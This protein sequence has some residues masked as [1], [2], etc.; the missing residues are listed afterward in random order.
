[1][2]AVNASYGQTS[3]DTG[4][5]SSEQS[6]IKFTDETT[7]DITKPPYMIGRAD[8]D[9]KRKVLK[10]GINWPG[11]D[12]DASTRIAMIE[13][14]KLYR[15]TQAQLPAE[16]A[17]RNC[18]TG[19][20]IYFGLHKNPNRLK[21]FFQPT[22]LK[23]TARKNDMETFE[24]L[25]SGTNYEYIDR[26]EPAT[27]FSA[28][29]INYQESMTVRSGRNTVFY[30]RGNF[31]TDGEDGDSRKVF[32]TFQEIIKFYDFM[33]NES[34]SFY[35]GNIYIHNAGVYLPKRKHSLYITASESNDEDDKASM[36]A[37]ASDFG[38]DLAHVCPSVCGTLSYPTDQ[39]LKEYKEKKKKK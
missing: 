6:E 10:S 13:L 17:G 28:D 5:C 2:T 32:Y 36:N 14:V 12:V 1:M 7:L 27:T 22:I 20:W 31:T 16:C 11:R 4:R 38:T 34:G 24:V 33:T 35:C 29:V 30:S 39:Q 8:M 15:Q 21:Y 19:F 37:L 25:V 9:E 26:F 23:K 3:P 18:V